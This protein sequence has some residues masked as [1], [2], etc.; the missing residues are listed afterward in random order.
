MEKRKRNKKSIPAK[1]LIADWFLQ[2]QALMDW[3]WGGQPFFSTS[4]F[5]WRCIF[6]GLLSL[7]LFLFFYFTAMEYLVYLLLLIFFIAHTINWVFNG[8]GYQ[9]LFILLNKKYPKDNVMQHLLGLKRR[10][11]EKDVLSVVYG[12]ICRGEMDEY[13]DVDIYVI[14]VNGLRYGLSMAMLN[15]CERLRAFSKGVS[16]DIYCVDDISYLKKRVKER[17]REPFFFIFSG[18]L[19]RAYSLELP[20][21]EFDLNILGAS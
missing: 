17:G 14:N 11:I 15:T 4:E 1:G 8:H 21:R 7:V 12:S 16:L 18:R 13:S 6:E 5:I 2:D 3:L 20:L 9:I 19:N 10:L